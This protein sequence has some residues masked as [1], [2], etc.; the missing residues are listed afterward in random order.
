M[1]SNIVSFKGNLPTNNIT[2]FQKALAQTKQ[3]VGVDASGGKQ[4]L[5][6]AKNGGYWVYGPKDTEVE[7]GSRW[8][9]NPMSLK[10]GFVAWKG[11]KPVGER[12]GSI[13][14]PPITR[15]SLDDVGAKWDEA[16]AFDLVCVSGEDEGTETRYNANS[17]GGRK[18]FTAVMD[19]LMKQTTVDPQNIVPIVELKSD[20]YDHRE[21]GKTYNPLFNIVGWSSMGAPP[22]AEEPADEPAEAPVAETKAEAP[23]EEPARRRRGAVTDVA[24]EPAKEEPARRQRRRAS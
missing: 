8:A 7:E 10:T 6:L 19:D 21:Y 17:Y 5:K 9:I 18:A 1:T 4:F 20:S 3:A 12:M 11:G 15:D 14:N 24:P 23:K 2:V 13:F 22:A 16:I